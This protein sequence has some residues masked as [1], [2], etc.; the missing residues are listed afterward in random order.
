MLNLSKI[1]VKHNSN[2]NHEAF[3]RLFLRIGFSSLE[4][5][6]FGTCVFSNKI[7][8]PKMCKWNIVFKP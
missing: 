3:S 2:N 1:L 8:R 5:K 4:N 7:F 6:V